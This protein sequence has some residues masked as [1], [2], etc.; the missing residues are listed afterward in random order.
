MPN[1]KVG[2]RKTQQRDAVLRVLDESEGP[3]SIEEVHE[4]S[5]DYCKNVG[6]ATVY[7]T[8]KILMEQERVDKVVLAD[9]IS[10][11]EFPDLPAHQYFLCYD[12]GAAY[13]IEVGKVSWTKTGYKRKKFKV[14]DHQLCLLGSCP[15]CK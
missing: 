15:N 8:I 6:I 1:E 4:L 7:R 9:G 5:L 13:R 2:K 11:Y 14:E 10:R 12:C 3:L